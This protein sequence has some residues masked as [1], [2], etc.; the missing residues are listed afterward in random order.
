MAWGYPHESTST[1]TCLYCGDDMWDDEY[2]EL[3]GSPVCDD[4]IR[5]LAKDRIDEFLEKAAELI[6][7]ER[8]TR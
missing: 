5:Q 8:V 1:T 7:A 3:D 4:C 6:G 2:Y